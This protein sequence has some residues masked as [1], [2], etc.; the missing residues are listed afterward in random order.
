MANTR[1]HTSPETA[2]R[3]AVRSATT[4]PDVRMRSLR[5]SSIGYLR[6]TASGAVVGEEHLLQRRFP[7]Q[8]VAD[9]SAGQQTQEGLHRPCHLAAQ[10]VAGDHDGV[11]S[12]DAG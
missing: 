2:A 12:R 5:S 6:S 1:P 11:N 8:E 7:A 10:T 4:A 9:A 3:R